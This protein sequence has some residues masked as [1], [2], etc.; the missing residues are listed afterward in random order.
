M[1]HLQNTSAICMYIVAPSFQI[2]ASEWPHVT[3]LSYPFTVH[4]TRHKPPV[5]TPPIQSPSYAHISTPVVKQRGSGRA[6]LE[7]NSSGVA[8]GGAEAEHFVR[9]GGGATGDGK[10]PSPYI[11]ETRHS[12][13]GYT[14]LHETGSEWK[15]L[16]T[17]RSGFSAN[18]DDRAADTTRFTTRGNA[19]PNPWL[20]ARTW[21]RRHSRM[22]TQGNW[23]ILGAA[24]HLRSPKVPSVP[25]VCLRRGVITMWGD[26]D[27][28]DYDAGWLRC[29]YNGGKMWVLGCTFSGVGFIGCPLYTV[30]INLL[31]LS[32]S[33][34]STAIVFFERERCSHRR[35]QFHSL[36]NTWALGVDN[37]KFRVE[38]FGLKAW[39]IDAVRR[40]AWFGDRWNGGSQSGLKDEWMTRAAEAISGLKADLEPPESRHLWLEPLPTGY[41]L[42]LLT[43]ILANWIRYVKEHDIF[44]TLPKHYILEHIPITQSCLAVDFPCMV[45][46]CQWS[47]ITKR[48]IDSLSHLS[49][50]LIHGLRK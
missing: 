9:G 45:E 33:L 11:Y 18:L 48:S 25:I 42:E 20:G 37:I 8:R 19:S 14:A 5:P 27:V 23:C 32:T 3:T 17:P 22:A 10:S 50:R 38:A 47:S 43:T 29:G 35:I 34:V 26:Y 2:T 41:L 40:Q 28:G 6:S 16:T 21:C 39:V 1:V 44:R 4:C 13:Q 36:F 30:E 15:W 49:S 46:Q 7:R 31:Y 12:E 24:G